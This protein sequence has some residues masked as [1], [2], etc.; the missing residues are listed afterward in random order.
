MSTQA[1]RIK[2]GVKKEP[3]SRIGFESIFGPSVRVRFFSIKI[4]SSSS[5]SRCFFRFETYVP[6]QVSRA[7]SSF[8]WK[9]DRTGTDASLLYTRVWITR[10]ISRYCYIHKSILFIDILFTFINS[11][12]LLH[13]RLDLHISV[14]NIF[15]SQHLMVLLSMIRYKQMIERTR[16]MSLMVL[17]I[18]ILFIL[19]R[20]MTSYCRFRDESYDV[21]ENIASIR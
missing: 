19:V 20:Q 10:L 16:L 12:A 21:K 14:F 9:P 15:P 3:K 11:F 6:C 4:G 7:G 8:C 5:M 2:T 1:H 17:S 13:N 18:I